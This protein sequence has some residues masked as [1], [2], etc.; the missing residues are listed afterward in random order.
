MP[1]NGAEQRKST[2]RLHCLLA[3]CNWGALRA[4]STGTTEDLQHKRMK[5]TLLTGS[6]QWLLLLSIK[7]SETALLCIYA[8]RIGVNIYIN[9]DS[10]R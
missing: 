6:I 9:G 4:L 7:I 2:Q 5:P 1:F 3:H 10:V 8:I